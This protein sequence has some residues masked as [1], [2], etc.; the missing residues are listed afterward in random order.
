MNGGDT[1]ALQGFFK[2]QIEIGRI[3]ANEKHGV[4]FKHTVPQATA[5]AKNFAKTF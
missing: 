2:G 4:F 5:D 1:R 3:N